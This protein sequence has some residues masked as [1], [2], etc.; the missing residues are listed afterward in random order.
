MSY[1][2][3]YRKYRSRNFAELVGQT[4]IVQTLQ[5]AIKH[6]RIAHAYLFSGPRGTGKTSA[7][8]IFAK[9]LNCKK[10]PTPE[11]CDEC[12]NCAKI[13][14]GH[15]ADV[16]EIDA[17]SNRG[18]DEIRELRERVRYAPLEGRYK[19]YIID[20]V[21]MLTPEAFNA[22]LKT[23]EEPPAH[24]LFI[25]ATT[26]LQ[27]VPLT[28]ASRCQRLDFARLKLNDIKGQLQ[29]IAKSEKFQ[30]EDKALELIARSAEGAMRDAISLLDQLV[31]FSSGQITYDDV[32]T[33]LGTADEALLFGFADAVAANDPNQVLALVRKGM[34]EGRSMQQVTRELVFHF[35]NLMHLK[36]GT[37]EAL[38]LTTDQLQRLGEQAKKFSLERIK[39]VLRALSRAELD[40]KWHPYGR[41]VLEVALL[42]LLEA[43]QADAV[44]KRVSESDVR[45]VIATRTSP[46]PNETP[47]AAATA[48]HIP[49]DGSLAGIKDH[50]SA[51][52]ENMRKKSIYGFVSLHEG[53]PIELAQSG[54]LVIGFRK[55]YSFHKERLE[56]AKNKEA[57]EESIREV[58]GH[59]IPVECI[60]SDRPNSPTLSVNSVA[61]FFNGKVV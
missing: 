36:A 26:E 58:V 8:R 31:S 19:V 50:W 11:P 45:P 29:K 35:R 25:L 15:S 24:T 59:R 39:E 56:E 53:E 54:K 7:A 38:E 43:R 61:E 51:I 44:A 16:I 30:I 40:M 27:K 3:L 12:E 48:G 52:L 5:N 42:E 32:V 14:G 57:L 37:G 21:H 6:D 20:E 49:S 47:I 10:G 34:E 41:L 28:I 18:I 55:G 17:A 9:A 23:L 60:I 2:S 33:L 1:V 46:P 22:L 4:V 13:K